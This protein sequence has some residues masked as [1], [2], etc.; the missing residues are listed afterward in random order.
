LISLAVQTADLLLMEGRFC[1]HPKENTV[2]CEKETLIRRGWFVACLLI[3]LKSQA[4]DGFAQTVIAQVST[5]DALAFNNATRLVRGHDGKIHLAYHDQGEIFYVVSSDNGDSWSAPLNIS[6]SA[7]RSV[8]PAL[9][10]DSTRVHF[11]WQDDT[12]PNDLNRIDGK[13]RIWFKSFR[14]VNANPLRFPYLIGEAV[15]DAVTPALTVIDGKTLQAVWAANMGLTIGWEINISTGVLI[16]NGLLDLYDWTY[17]AIPG[18]AL[19][20]SSSFFPSIGTANE[21]SYV[22]WQEL[23]AFGTYMSVFK[24][25]RN[26]VWSQ[27]QFLGYGTMF[28][29]ADEMGVP[30]LVFSNHGVALF[31]FKLEYYAQPIDVDDVFVVSLAE[32]DTLDESDGVRVS[33]TPEPESEVKLVLSF[34]NEIIATWEAS[35]DSIGRIYFSKARLINY[36]KIWTS[37]ILI[38]DAAV[39]SH[40]PQ[41]IAIDPDTL[42]FVWLQGSS[43]PFEIIAEKYPPSPTFVEDIWWNA[44]SRPTI[45]FDISLYPNPAYSTTNFEI[46]IWDSGWL[47]IKI[48][49]LQGQVIKTIIEREVRPFKF[50]FFWDTTDEKKRLAASGLYIVNI[51]LNQTRVT[52]KLML[53]R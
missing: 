40:D 23:N 53:L 47:S 24:S 27:T 8:F 25:Q 19:G 5:K 46:E 10:V 42:L 14:D 11:A 50:K 43:V 12:D 36:D 33:N 37:P 38:S 3:F 9:A 44:S 26:Q 4:I 7:G 30:S 48:L 16:G 32:G 15:G 39:S 20:L 29:G 2:K 41:V 21:M 52:R 1:T 31:G 28:P 51:Q 35:A 18:Q 45:P 17:P 22:A 13:Q 49:N 6:F 34:D